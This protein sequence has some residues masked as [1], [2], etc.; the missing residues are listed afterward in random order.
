MLQSIL[1]SFALPALL[2][3]PRTNNSAVNPDPLDAILTGTVAYS[4]PPPGVPR[5]PWQYNK[6][7][8]SVYQKVKVLL[9]FREIDVALRNIV[10]AQ[11]LSKIG[12]QIIQLFMDSHDMAKMSGCQEVCCKPL[13]REGAHVHAESSIGRRMH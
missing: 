10:Q 9:E 5:S 6:A 13:R 2:E 7:D 1:R 11:G 4:P 8:T 12:R 3:S